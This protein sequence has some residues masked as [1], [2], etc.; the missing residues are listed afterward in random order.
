MVNYNGLGDKFNPKARKVVT[1]LF[2]YLQ[3]TSW[4]RHIWPGSG[5]RTGSSEHVT[6]RAI[7]IITVSRTGLRPSAAQ[8]AAAKQLADLLIQ[9]GKALGIQWVLYS[10]DGKVTW[11]YN[12]DRGTWKALGDRGAVSA[13]HVDHI[14]VYFK[15][16]VRLPAGFKWAAGASAGVGGGATPKPPA[17]KPPASKPAPELV[18]TVSVASLK[19]ARYA[20]PPMAGRPVGTAGNQVYTLEAALVRTGWLAPRYRDGHYGSTTVEAVQGFQRKHS[21]ASKPDGWMGPEEL[22]RLFR[23]AGMSTRVT[24]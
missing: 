15:T 11:Y 20:D 23:L 12:M 3:G 6:G 14:H 24:S 13:N 2:D 16:S 5:W 19:R 7:D 9:H 4:G 22:R 18:G 1:S 8:H 21:G 17:P 10:L